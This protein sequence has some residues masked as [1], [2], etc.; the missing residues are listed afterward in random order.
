MHKWLPPA[1]DYIPRWL[2]FQ[3]RMTRQPGCVIA[4]M[5][6]DRLMLEQAFGF[7]DLARRIPMTPRHRFRVASHSKSFTAAG[8][9]KLR[10]AGKLGLDDPAG[11]FV[12]GLHRDVGR[13]TVGLLLSHGGGLP[14]D[15]RDAGQFFDRRP[16]LDRS[17]LL[18]DL[19]LAP[20][21]AAS[22]RFKYSNHGYGLLGLIIEAVTGEDYATWMRREI[23]D[24]L[25]L[26]ETTPDMPLPKRA[27]LALGHTGEMP[28]G[29]RAGVPGTAPGRAMASAAGF[30][31]TARDLARFFAQ[32]APGARKSVLSA[33]SRREMIRRHWRN[34]DASV[35]GHYGYGLASGTL[36]GWDWF[37]HSG[38]LQ[39]FIT[40][41]CVLPEQELTISILTNAVDG[42]APLW[43]D[44]TIQILRGF[45]QHGPPSHRARDWTGRWWTLWGA[46]DLV[47]MGDGVRVAVPAFL[48]PLADASEITVTGRDKGRIS[49][50]HGYA[51]H[52]EPVR[53]VRGASG[54]VT[55]LWLG[56]AEL[57][58]EQ[59]LAREIEARYGTR[60]TRRKT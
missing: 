20:P 19:A 37:G 1:L 24:T 30:V 27:R 29:R 45:A 33:A 49:R 54:K 60:K 35:D 59:R 21:I 56:G 40:R 48:N 15:G 10:E 43:V 22:S 32:L 16:Y 42:W 5:H 23:L 18:A 26:A 34:P 7:A 39:G 46:N 50:A 11:R 52:G 3:M 4:V 9:L 6:R 41:T 38:G 17:E 31:S 25:S 58:P 8:V 53:R 36:G 12:K 13:A 44:G 28:L 55:A 51:S 47:P 14:R 2:D 57:V